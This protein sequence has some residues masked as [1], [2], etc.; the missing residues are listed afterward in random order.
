MRRRL[1]PAVVAVAL[2]SGVAACGN[3]EP[4]DDAVAAAELDRP[5]RHQGDPAAF[6]VPPDPLPE[7]RPGDLLRYQ[8]LGVVGG[9]RGYK[10]L[11]LS[12]SVA[13]EPIAVS[14]LAA[15]PDDGSFDRP[16]LSWAHGTTGLADA[17]A[18]SKETVQGPVELLLAEF[19][20]RGW[21]VTATDYEG[22]GTPGL[23]PYL[24][25]ISEGRAVLDAIRA[26]RQ[27]PAARAG[28]D[29]VVWGHSQG[30]HAALFANELAAGWAPELRVRGVVAGAPPSELPLLAGALRGGAYQ[31]YLAM[32]AGGLHTAYPE[33]DLDVVFAE[34]TVEELA[35]LDEGCTAEVFQR[36]NAIPPDDFFRGNPLED[37]TWKRVLEENDP[38]HRRTEIPLLIVHGEDDEQIPVALS[39]V[40]FE[41]LCD[42][43]Q[44][45]ER[46]T[47]PDQGH[48]E[49]VVAAFG[50]LSTW[51]ADRLAGRPARSTCPT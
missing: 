16:V 22:L 30:G 24:A 10:I 49:V 42:L 26:A 44:V 41:R 33:T 38:G 15:L 47:Y 8:D 3:D 7:G 13:G 9:G 29:A 1:L 11:Y 18:P 6:Y 17:C 39:G 50:E 27:L 5:V 12:E 14:G 23:H 48:A 19:L 51:M 43:G 25:G 31:G 20:E 45:V 21:V 2:A 32:V 40:L 46:R 37:P 35:L 28:T 4:P 36:F 34:D